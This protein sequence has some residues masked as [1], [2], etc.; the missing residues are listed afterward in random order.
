MLQAATCQHFKA[1]RDVRVNLSPLT[2]IVGPNAS[3][4][5]SILEA[6]YW[7][8]ELC[9]KPPEELF[10]DYDT[11]NQLCAVGAT[12]AIRLVIQGEWDK[13]VGCLEFDARRSGETEWEFTLAGSWGSETIPWEREKEAF[14]SWPWQYTQPHIARRVLASAALLH[15]DPS[16]ISEPSYSEDIN[17][18]VESDGS[19]LAAVLADLAVSEPKRFQQ[20]HDS[21]QAVVPS[22]K[23]L[24]LKRAKIETTELKKVRVEGT[25]YYQ[26][27]PTKAIGH[28]IVLD[29][30]AGNGLDAKVASEGTLLALGLLTLLSAPSRPHLVLVDELER[31]LHPK[32]LGELIRQIRE[33]QKRFPDLQVIGTTHSPY[34]VDHFDAGDVIL[35]TLREDGS[36]AAG[37]LNEH[38]EFERWKDEMKPGEFWSTVGEDWLRDKKEPG[39]E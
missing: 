9:K 10:N 19:N 22:V 15:L 6:L 25:D 14:E 32:A 8:A 3:G 34:L 7:L 31:G 29:F 20:L 39:G 24:R 35:T 33:L 37:R 21:L 17:L 11:L 18:C 38:P 27:L 28:R 23:G 12:D 2:L 13:T 4:K 26:E 1:L 30:P 36:V 16:A 5:T